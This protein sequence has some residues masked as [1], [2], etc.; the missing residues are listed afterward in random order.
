LVDRLEKDVRMRILAVLTA[1]A[2]LSSLHGAAADTVV[3]KNGL[4]RHGAVEETDGGVEVRLD[5]TTRT[6]SRDQIREVRKGG[7]RHEEFSSR[8][9]AL[10]ADDAAGWYKLALWARE[11]GVAR[12]HEALERVVAIDPDHRAARRELGYEKIGAD[13][14]SAD[15]ARRKKGF[16]KAGGRWVLPEEADRLMREGLMEQAEVTAEHRQLAKEIVAALEDDDDDVRAAAAEM[17]RELPDAALV[18]PM[19]RLL[20]APQPETRI[21]AVKTLSRIGDRTALPWLIQT[22]MYDAKENVRDAAF[23][24]IRSFGDE[25]VFFPYARA[26]FKPSP[27][28][29]IQAAEALAAL[30]DIRGVDVILRR[31]SIGIGASGRANIL[32]GKQQSYIQDFD[33]EIAQAAAIGDPIVQ[34]IRD[35]VILDYKIL[36]GSGEQWIAEQRTAYA[37]A[38][39]KLTGRDYGEDWKAYAAYAAE[40]DYPRVSIR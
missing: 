32:V 17:L 39:K 26:L 9:A 36:G 20:L 5:G 22:S 2:V 30:G 24:A 18:R 35:G 4:E 14:L 11:N 7:T 37:S 25:D 27:V 8:A 16:V 13:W 21:L 28:S 19:R 38:L 10:G 31:V 34:T 6:F 23:R 29:R 1:T 3:L 12:V 15:E 33:V 40:H